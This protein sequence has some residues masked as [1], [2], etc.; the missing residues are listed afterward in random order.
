LFLVEAD[1]LSS[2]HRDNR[3]S[4]EI[5]VLGHERDGFGLCGWSCAQFSCAIR[6]RPSVEEAADVGIADQRLQL[7]LAQRGFA[8]VTFLQLCTQAQQETSCLTTGR[9]GG[10]VIEDDRLLGHGHFPSVSKLPRALGRRC[11]LTHLHCDYLTTR[12]GTGAFRSTSL[13][14]SP[15][16]TGL[17]PLRPRDPMTIRSH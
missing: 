2:P 8:E 1:H 11:S 16:V 12:T 3:P 15:S 14:V 6:R 10:L 4:D 9:S 17:K 7:R 5:R 13:P